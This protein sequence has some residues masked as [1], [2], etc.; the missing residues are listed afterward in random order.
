VVTVLRVRNATRV[1]AQLTAMRANGVSGVRA[2]RPVVVAIQSALAIRPRHNMEV[3]SVLTV[4]IV[5]Y[6]TLHIALLCANTVNG[7]AGTS[8]LVHAARALRPVLVV[9]QI[10]QIA[11]Q[12]Q[13][14]LGHAIRNDVEGKDETVT[15]G[16]NCY[17]ID[18]SLLREISPYTPDFAR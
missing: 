12:K 6:A 17:P 8:A 9:L 15:H 7:L 13:Q 10:M 3:A 5:A 16:W 4:L 2:P 14:Q 11:A 18:T 1:I